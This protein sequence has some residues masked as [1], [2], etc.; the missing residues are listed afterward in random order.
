MK[1]N[2]SFKKKE[3]IGSFCEKGGASL[4][5]KN[6]A[7]TVSKQHTVWKVSKDGIISGPYFHIFSP[8]NEPE[9]TPYFDIFHAVITRRKSLKNKYF[10][11]SYDYNLINTILTK[12]H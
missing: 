10:N 1:Q 8:N 2:L 9:I 11:D 5:P 3:I 12:R 6:L 7:E 4:F